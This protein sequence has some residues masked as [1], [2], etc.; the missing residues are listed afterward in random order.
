MM[1]E[2]AVDLENYISQNI[3]LPDKITKKSNE[4][5]TFIDMHHS[6]FLLYKKQSKWLNHIHCP[7]N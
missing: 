7:H 5:I 1:Q 4:F 2:A 3:I 6:W